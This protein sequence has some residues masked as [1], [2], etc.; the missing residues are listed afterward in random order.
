[1]I[2]TNK[3]EEKITANEHR[4]IFLTRLAAFGAA[5][6]LPTHKLLALA[7]QN[8]NKTR[9]IDLHQHFFPHAFITAA[10]E[11]YAPREQAI[12]KGWSPASALADMDKNGV[13]TGILSITTPGI[14]FGDAQQSRSLSRECNEY[15]AK[16]VQDYPERFGFFAAVPLPDTEGSLKEIAY[17]LD[18]LKADGIG[19]MTNYGD[20]WPGDSTYA[21]VFE[22]LNR[23]KAVV[24][25]HPTAADCCRSLMADVPA[26]LIE[27]PHDTSRAIMS[28]LYSGTFARFRNIRFIFSHAGGTIPILAGRIAQLGKL[29]DGDK[30]VPNGVEYELRR[31]YYEIA[32]SANR[33]A[34]SALMA[35][36]PTSQILFGSDNPFVPTDITGKGLK[37]LGLSNANIQAIARDNALILFPRLKKPR[38]K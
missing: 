10:L 21:P 37:S 34:M 20:K 18:V 8:D 13:A 11:K 3:Q 6:V 29:F 17:T 30:K 19:L 22:E 15:A 27:Y 23:R 5:I 35:L 31:L 2:E 25:F 26:P 1:M 36:V 12:V 4:R 24:Y 14:W 32:N 38:W 16:L 33:P 9:L 28:L 7:S